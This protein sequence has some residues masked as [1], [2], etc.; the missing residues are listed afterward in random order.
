VFRVS[1]TV[2]ARTETEWSIVMRFHLQVRTIMRR[3]GLAGAVLLII[4]AAGCNP[5]STVANIGIKVVG[6]A[7][8]DADVSD[9]ARQLIGQPESMA[10]AEFGQPLRTLEE[11]RSKRAM[12]I[13]PV[14]DDVLSMYR[15]AVEAQNGKIVAL[16]KL[17]NDPDDGKDIIEKLVLKELVVGK[18]PQEIQ[19]KDWFK[20]LILTLR[21]RATGQTLRIYDVSNITDFL[22]SRDCVLEFDASDRCQKIWLVGVP[23]A[24]PQSRLQQ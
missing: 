13:Y 23:A 3:I 8:N 14:K 7:V 20:N 19:A 15:W 1:S 17:Q 6:D 9:H 2:E 10:N 24:T 11:V 22:G 21:D 12:M 16:A 4:S 5:Y 18:T